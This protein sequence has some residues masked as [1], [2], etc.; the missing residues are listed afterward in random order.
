[1]NMNMNIIEYI[2]RIFCVKKSIRKTPRFLT[3]KQKNLLAVEW[4]RK[5][6]TQQQLMNDNIFDLI[7]QYNNETGDYPSIHDVFDIF[8]I[9]RG[10]VNGKYYYFSTA[11]WIQKHKTV[12]PAIIIVLTNSNEI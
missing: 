5:N 12:Y 1:M 6:L 7:R 3:R 4:F 11:P 9:I 2:K 10:Q 8:N